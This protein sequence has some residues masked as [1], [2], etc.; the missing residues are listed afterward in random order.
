M[1][2]V[3][4]ILYVFSWNLVSFETLKIKAFATIY[5][6]VVLHCPNTTSCAWFRCDSAV[7]SGFL[8]MFIA[9]IVCLKLVSFAHT[10]HDIRQLTMSDKKV[11][12]H[13]CPFL[14]YALILCL[15]EVDWATAKKGSR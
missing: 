13:H 15:D 9:C 1:S 7:V 14:L 10:N 2:N 12:F 5:D 6:I 4:A 8:L 11:C 3:N